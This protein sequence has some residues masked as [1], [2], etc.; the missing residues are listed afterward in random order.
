MGLELIKGI[1][2]ATIKKL[3]KAGV[4]TLDDLRT[5]DV[6]ATE[7]KTGISAD[8]LNEWKREAQLTKVLEDIKGIGPA[9]KKKLQA[10]G[11]HDLD[12]LAR[13]TV[14]ELAVKTNLA[15]QRVKSW[16][17][18]ADQWVQ[19]T[20]KDV[21]TRGKEAYEKSRQAAEQATTRGRALAKE[22]TERGRTA[23]QETRDQI[24]QRTEHARTNGKTQDEP[25]FFAKLKAI[26]T[27]KQS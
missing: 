15:E 5:I 17:K 11:I 23:V 1:G 9:V 13:A 20:S 6:A 10:A 26:F 16:Q 4:R 24:A 22:A 2:P 19:K 14:H 8:R 21:Q 18:E 27:G 3:D 25:G 12:D 7:E